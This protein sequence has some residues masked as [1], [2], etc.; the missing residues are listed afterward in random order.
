MVESFEKRQRERRKR[1]KQTEK[2]ERRKDKA[3]INKKRANG[4]LPPAPR[5]TSYLEFENGPNGGPRTEGS[6]S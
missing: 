3:E 4:E 5:D 6:S 2:R 1:D